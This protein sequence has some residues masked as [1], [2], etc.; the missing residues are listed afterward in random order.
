MDDL[1]VGRGHR[2]WYG[3]PRTWEEAA[4]RAGALLAIG[5]AGAAR[6]AH[7]LAVL[8]RRAA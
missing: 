4:R 2:G 8:L 3:P 1:I 7:D 6:R 5:E